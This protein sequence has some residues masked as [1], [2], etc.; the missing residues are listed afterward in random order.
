[1]ME[2]FLICMLT[3]TA[4][5]HARL[6]VVSAI[7]ATS[8]PEHM[9]RRLERDTWFMLTVVCICGLTLGVLG[10]WIILYALARSLFLLFTNWQAACDNYYD[11]KRLLNG[12]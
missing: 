5:I 12:N 9:L 6:T 7:N 3:A 1:M 8:S 10:M 11:I 4:W 2:F